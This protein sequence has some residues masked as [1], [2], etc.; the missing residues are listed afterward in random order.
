[1]KKRLV[2]ITGLIISVLI[3][4]IAFS[5][6]QAK[7]LTP[8][9]SGEWTVGRGDTLWQIAAENRGNTEIRRYIYQIQKLNAIGSTIYPGQVLLLP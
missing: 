6:A 9:A 7:T 2:I 8:A 1:M 3:T 5:S 4:M